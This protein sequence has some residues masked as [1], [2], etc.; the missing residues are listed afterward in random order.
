MPRCRRCP[1]K[2][3]GVRRSSN[4]GGPLMHL[5]G[6]V[7]KTYYDFYSPMHG[8]MDKVKYFVWQETYDH[9]FLY[10]LDFAHGQGLRS[11]T[12]QHEIVSCH[13]AST[14]FYY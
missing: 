8:P 7:Q 3:T 5:V 10:D 11:K 1:T 12:Y 9:L 2:I 6:K 14:Y 13:F 4:V